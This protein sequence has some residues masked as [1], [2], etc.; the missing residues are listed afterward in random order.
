MSDKRVQE[1]VAAKL[2]AAGLK[3]HAIAGIMGNIAHESGFNPKASNGQTIG[4]VQW[5]GSRRTDL[6]NFAKKRGGS[7]TD[8]D[9]QID[10]MLKEITSGRQGV[11]V[12]SLNGAGGPQQA[13]DQFFHKYERANDSTGPTRAATAKS[14][15][16]LTNRVSKG[17]G[18]TQPDT[19]SMWSVKKGN[20][21]YQKV[22]YQGK[23]LD[24]RT[25]A[26][27]K[28]ASDMWSERI[29][30]GMQIGITQGSYNPG[31]VKASAGT[32]DG[33]GVLDINTDN[34]DPKQ[35]ARAVRWL[36][37]AGFAAW[38]RA[39]S[40]GPWGD[41]IHAVLLDHKNL[42]PGA[43]N[44][45]KDYL[46]GGNG[47]GG[48]DTEWRPKVLK[49]WKRDVRYGKD[50]TGLDKD[51]KPVKGDYLEAIGL[52][53]QALGRKGNE[54]LEELV[55][56]AANKEWTNTEFTR[57]FK[58]TQWY[59]DRAQSQREFDMLQDTEQQQLIKQ[60]MA[61]ADRGAM[62]YG[63][64]LSPEDKR[65]LAIK[66]ARDGFT[67]EQAQW[68]ISRRYAPKD[69]EFG[70]ALTAKEAWK[71]TARDYGVRLSDS[72]MNGWVQKMIGKQL[73]PDSFNDNIRDMAVSSNAYLRDAYAK[74]LTTRE[75][76]APFLSTASAVLGA[77]PDTFDLSDEKWTRT[78]F[79]ANGNQISDAAWRT[80]L[81]S[82]ARFG[83]G[84]T[85]NGA[86]EARRV[87][88]NMARMMGVVGNG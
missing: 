72:V 79:D 47:L 88:R 26:A 9:I 81:K 1:K 87:G 20:D 21:P 62:Q 64:E 35:R 18:E 74:G 48:K 25:R 13:S 75:A 32:H 29:G 45:A 65:K 28:W 55:K 23:T 50:G 59:I 24:R 70:A 4:L 57:R 40:E 5:L 43:A 51:F 44:Q 63:V 54:E 53:G 22:T 46:N 61:K 31:G 58:K 49:P 8:L 16:K 36:R 86:D 27:F 7:A 39:A 34:M 85:K 68:F 12:K 73:N 67:D 42:S 82:D 15:M 6:Q 10:F 37:R 66:I 33:G 11:T 78:M 84:N 30:D 52:S 2:A 14:M 71:E 38:H 60:N 19:G 41:H 77:D 80:V 83:Y 69:D 17:A 56:R 76:L 3:P